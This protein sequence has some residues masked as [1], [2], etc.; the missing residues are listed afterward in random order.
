MFV[1]YFYCD[2]CGFEGLDLKVAYSRTTVSNHWYICPECG[3]ESCHA[4]NE[5]DGE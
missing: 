5:G 4:S 1:D 3:S 2:S